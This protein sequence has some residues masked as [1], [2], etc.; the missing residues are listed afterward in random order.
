VAL[1]RYNNGTFEITSLKQAKE[2]YALMQELT[3]AISELEKEHGI[4]DMRQDAV[5]LKYSADAF[6]VKSGKD[7][8]EIPKISKRATVVRGHDGHWIET[9]E[10]LRKFSVPKD[11]RTLRSIVGKDLWK[12]ITKRRLDPDKLAEAVATGE[13]DEDEIKAAYHEE[14]RKPYVRIYE[15][16]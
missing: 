7:H 8:L 15:D 11:A 3:D 6:L 10:D 5:N 12:K 14:P 16:G 4:T 13:I 1:K 2:A 9:K